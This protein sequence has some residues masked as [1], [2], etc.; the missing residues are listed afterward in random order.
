MPVPEEA[1]KTGLNFNKQDI[2]W[3]PVID[4]LGFSPTPWTHRSSY[5]KKAPTVKNTE[6]SVGGT[7]LL[8][9]QAPLRRHLGAAHWPQ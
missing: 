1:E 8:F 7:S 9:T 2:P 3:L 5:Q 4:K 6:S